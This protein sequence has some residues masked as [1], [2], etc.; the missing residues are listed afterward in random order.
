MGEQ[1]VARE[2]DA[3]EIAQMCR[4]V[5]AAREAGAFGFTTS[6]SRTQHAFDGH[7]IPSR[8][9]TFAE[10]DALFAALAEGGG[11]FAQASIGRLEWLD[12]VRGD[13][14]A[15][16]HCLRLDRAPVGPRRSGLA[17]AAAGPGAP[18]AGR[19]LSGRAA[20]LTA[21][22]GVRVHLRLSAAVGALRVDPAAACRQAGGARR[23]VARPGLRRRVPRR[24]ADRFRRLAERLGGAHGDRRGAARRGAERAPPRRRRRR[25]RRRPVR[26]RGRAQRRQW[27]RD[28]FPPAGAELPRGRGRG[29]PA[30]S[31]SASSLSRTPARMQASSATSTTPPICCSTGCARPAR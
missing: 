2:A 20:D 16:W 18:L 8:L 14:P 6:L 4:I 28:A 30:R 15:P 26:S 27:A 3:D 13:R 5:R 22:P 24:E 9:A 1:A 12:G 25:A 31:E 7:P 11:G 17:P 23:D 29:D 21:A 19:G 10:I